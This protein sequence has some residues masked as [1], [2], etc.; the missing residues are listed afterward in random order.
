MRF[1]DGVR[2]LRERSVTTFLELGPD[3]VLTA[4]AQDAFGAEESSGDD[5]PWPPPYC[6][7]GT[8]RTTRC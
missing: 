2:A 8:P 4:N 5:A 1:H 3:P 6:A 7:P